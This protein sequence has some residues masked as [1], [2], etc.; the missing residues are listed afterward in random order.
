MS[1][2]N[3]SAVDKVHSTE[4]FNDEGNRKIRDELHEYLSAKD[5][6]LL[7]YEAVYPLGIYQNEKLT[8]DIFNEHKPDNPRMKVS[9]NP[10]K[11]RIY[12]SLLEGIII[13]LDEMCRIENSSNLVM[14]S[15]HIDFGI[16]KEALE[17]LGY[18]KEE[19]HRNTV[20]GFDAVD[21]KVVSK[22]IL[23]RIEGIDV[24]VKH[25]NTIEIDST[26]S[27]MTVAADII[28]NTLYRHIKSKIEINETLRL[29]SPKA[30]EGY[31]LKSKAAFLGNDYVM[32]DLYAP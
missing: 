10:Q 2:L 29:H 20:T 12:N 15:D 4:L 17:T 14:V 25:V 26:T 5:E 11:K 9:K 7:V 31:V 21:K 24:S 18:L 3:I 27:S 32:D 13:K 1:K 8:L 30:L 19:E 22:D 6:W 16:H 28:A 23:S